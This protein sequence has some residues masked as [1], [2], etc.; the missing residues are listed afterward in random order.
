[1]GIMSYKTNSWS[2]PYR[3]TQNRRLDAGHVRRRS[4]VIP[5]GA[6]DVQRRKHG[7]SNKGN[8]VVC[9]YTV[10]GEIEVPYQLKAEK[11]IA[12][13]PQL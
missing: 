4:G 12:A 5:G 10:A 2:G 3:A 1:M 13:T 11:T 7:R 8:P 9:Q 6:A